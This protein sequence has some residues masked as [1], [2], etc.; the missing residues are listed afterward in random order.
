VEEREEDKKKELIRDRV[1]EI[2]DS[3]TGC[4]SLLRRAKKASIMTS[5]SG[6]SSSLLAV[7]LNL[8]DII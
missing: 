5:Q 6:S 7:E 4:I 1:H 8:L 2:K 3:I